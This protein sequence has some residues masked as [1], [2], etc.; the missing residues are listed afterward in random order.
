M[1]KDVKE[2]D[3]RIAIYAAGKKKVLEQILGVGTEEGFTRMLLTEKIGGMVAG[4][5]ERT[6]TVPVL[7][8]NI[9]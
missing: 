8:K 5:M 4:T 2:N 1:Q 6:N 7:A 3:G 9:I